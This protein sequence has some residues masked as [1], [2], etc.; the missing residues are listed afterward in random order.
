M[1][2]SWIDRRHQ[3]CAVGGAVAA[4]SAHRARGDHV[5]EERADSGDE[6]EQGRGT[7][8]S[9]ALDVA[10]AH[11]HQ[12]Q[13]G[14]DAEHHP[15]GGQPGEGARDGRHGKH[16]ARAVQPSGRHRISHRTVDGPHTLV[17]PENVRGNR[18]DSTRASD[19]GTTTMKMIAAA[20]LSS[21][22]NTSAAASIKPGAEERRRAAG[23]CRDRVHRHHL[24]AG[25]HVRK[26][27]GKARGDEPGEP[28]DDQRAEQ[29]GQSPAPD[30][31]SAAMP[32]TRT[33]L[34]RLAPISTDRRSH[35]SSRAPANG[36]STE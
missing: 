15:M 21:A 26:R 32:S 27:R 7:E 14:V 35:R 18:T 28:V 20:P 3:Q 5:G 11:H 9:D 19:T 24:L 30:A 8:T 29:D 31:S 10:V 33:S 16:R 1:P 25:H 4:P 13:H 23:G 2:P 6:E 17:R 36:P 12:H 34:A 22:P